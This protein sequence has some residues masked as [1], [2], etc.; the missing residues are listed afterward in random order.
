MSAIN[1]ITPTKRKADAHFVVT[2]TKGDKLSYIPTTNWSA[3]YKV[4]PKKPLIAGA[5]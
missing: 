4:G 1:S 5:N 3:L 2:T